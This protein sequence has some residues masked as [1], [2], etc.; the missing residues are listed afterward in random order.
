[1][2]KICT[3]FNYRNTCTPGPIFS[4][5]KTFYARPSPFLQ[6]GIGPP[7]NQSPLEPILGED[8]LNEYLDDAL[9]H[10][11]HRPAGYLVTWFPGPT[12]PTCM[13]VS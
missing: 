1:M 9:S 11:A 3:W 12:V 7:D 13:I 8:L 10:G 6:R 2:V 4:G 5:S